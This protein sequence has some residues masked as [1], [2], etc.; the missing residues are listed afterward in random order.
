MCRSIKVLRD[1]EIPATD[2]QCHE[3]ALQFVRKIS[4]TR[5]PSK[6]NQE[7]FDRA[8]REVA[9]A[10]RRLLDSMVTGP[11]QGRPSKTNSPA[12]SVSE[13]EP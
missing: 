1:A 11:G 4:G 8:V 2:L 10:S 7:V 3:A 13:L 5:K 12:R 9:A 6:M